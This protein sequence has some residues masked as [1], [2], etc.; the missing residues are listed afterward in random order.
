MYSVLFHTGHLH[1]AALPE[2]ESGAF[3]PCCCSWADLE[4]R[5]TRAEHGSP[6][7]LETEHLNC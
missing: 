6:G 4:H 1:C 3:Y 2:L 5:L 7:E